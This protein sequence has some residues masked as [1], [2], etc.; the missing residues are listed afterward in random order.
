MLQ[1]AYL[2]VILIYSHIISKYYFAMVSL[3]V[4]NTNL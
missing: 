1:L 4:S 3:F 2:Q